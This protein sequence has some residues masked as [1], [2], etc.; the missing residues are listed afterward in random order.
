MNIRQI[1]FNTEA[2]CTSKNAS[3]SCWALM[4]ALE[5]SKET[6]RTWE[7]LSW[8]L[9][10]KQLQTLQAYKQGCNVTEM[11][12]EPVSRSSVGW[13]R[14]NG[15]VFAPPGGYFCSGSLKEFPG[16]LRSGMPQKLLRLGSAAFQIGKRET[17]IWSKCQGGREYKIWSLRNRH[18]CV[19]SCSPN[20]PG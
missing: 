15:C 5:P 2:S 4:K 6:P 7:P 12:Q 9:N 16:L 11:S 13:L 14:A 3:S 20:Y 1:P 18:I 8:P 17:L 19:S 10:F